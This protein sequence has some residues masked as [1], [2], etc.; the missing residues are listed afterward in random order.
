MDDQPR[1]IVLLSRAERALVEANTVDEAKDVRDTA[2]AVALYAK[3]A[4]LGQSMAAE[5]S[6]VRL[7]AERRMGELLQANCTGDATYCTPTCGP[8][9][10]GALPI[11]H[12]AFHGRTGWPQADASASKHGTSDRWP[13]RPVRFAAHRA[14]SQANRRR[15]PSTDRR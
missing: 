1:E 14:P 4:K 5:A 10:L 6:A 13:P 11:L 9:L 2:A 3:K 15:H 8:D 12:I 7:R